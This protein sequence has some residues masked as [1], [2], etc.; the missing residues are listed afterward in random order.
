MQPENTWCYEGKD[1][2]TCMPELASQFPVSFCSARLPE[3]LLPITTGENACTLEQLV[4]LADFILI[5]LHFLVSRSFQKEFE[6][7]VKTLDV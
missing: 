1:T 3:S 2:W 5:N 6:Y 7:Q 4:S